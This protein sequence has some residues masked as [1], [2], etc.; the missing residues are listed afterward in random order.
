MSIIQQQQQQQHQHGNNIGDQLSQTQDGLDVYEV[1]LVKLRAS[2]AALSIAIPPPSTSTPTPTPTP[3]STTLPLSASSLSPLPSSTW[4]SSLPHSSQ[5]SSNSHSPSRI[6]VPTKSLT[7]S[8]RRA[9][10]AATAS[11][12]GHMRK[13]SAPTTPTTSTSSASTPTLFVS[14]ASSF[15]TS[16][17]VAVTVPPPPLPS[18]GPPAVPTHLI[19]AVSS[20]PIIHDTPGMNGTPKNDNNEHG[21]IGDNNGNGLDNGHDNNLDHDHHQHQGQDQGRQHDDNNNDDHGALQREIA[22]I[23]SI[24]NSKDNDW[25]KRCDALERINSICDSDDISATDKSV[26]MIPLIRPLITQLTELRSLIIKQLCHTITMISASLHDAF[27]SYTSLLPS[28]CN[29]LRNSKRA[30]S[31]PAD[32]CI[33]AIIQTS[34]APSIITLLIESHRRIRAEAL[35]ARIAYYLTVIVEEW[36]EQVLNDQRILLCDTLPS[37]LSHASSLVRTPARP[38]LECIWRRWRFDAITILTNQH[39]SIQVC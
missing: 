30:M 33:V 34:Y 9:A 3:P 20:Q 15:Q 1:K 14:P 11:V 23:C 31:S 5:S 6:P 25:N 10:A 7:G 35:S 8:P 22:L 4:S 18:R 16:T 38:L 2:M 17:T 21:G 12:N 28:I 26:I 29:L 19:S 27:E 37:L 36:P 24:L 32:A 13:S 39:P